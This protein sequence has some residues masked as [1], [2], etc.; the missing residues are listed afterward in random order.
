ME[1]ASK[2]CARTLFS[3]EDEEPGSAAKSL[4]TSES[5]SAEPQ[6]APEL[7]EPA[8]A[9]EKQDEHLWSPSS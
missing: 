6:K 4:K 9:S 8:S 1:R 5:P 2:Q 7:P 3:E